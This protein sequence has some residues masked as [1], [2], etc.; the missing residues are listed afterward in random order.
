MCGFCGIF[1]RSGSPIDG[2]I[3]GRM[4][5]AISH[6]G[7]DGEGRF[8]DREVG[9]GHRRLSIIDVEGGAQP[10]GNEDGSLQIVFNGEIYN[11]VELRKELEGAGHTFTTRSDTEVIVHAYEQWGK[12][13]VER[14]NGMFAFALWDSN[15][16]EVFLARDHLGVKP[17]YYVEL[18]GR[19]L[20]GSEIKALLQDQECPRDVDVESLAELF[21]FRYV[22][23]PKTL[24]NGI[25]KLPDSNI[26]I[27]PGVDCRDAD[28]A[29][30]VMRGEET[31]AM[32][33]GVDDGLVCLPGTHSKWVE[34]RGGRIV[35]FA[36]FIT[37]ELY[38]ALSK[39]FVA[40]LASEPEAPG[41]VAD[42]LAAAA[43]AGGL[44]RAL[45]QARTRVLGGLMPAAG[46]RPF[47]SGLL[48]GGEVAGGRAL[49]GALPAVHLVAGE[50]LLAPYREALA[51]HGVA[52]HVV[53][54]EAAFLSGLHRIAGA[55]GLLG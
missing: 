6:R 28:G 7:P 12:G 27:V 17:L 15:K 47:I 19:I 3:L 10:I 2:N 24:F 48:I 23:S 29:Y 40:R 20:F 50:P 13:C 21:T 5:S 53:D 1:D 14:F 45:F 46:V 30:D 42:G 26:R 37:G 55:A 54:P 18:G 16:R 35:R 43:L 52:A 32:G 33:A 11:F 51:A 36:S 25:R 22:P 9:L 41:H 31:Q 34:M 44:P 39:S 49:F 38:A 8:V 4:T